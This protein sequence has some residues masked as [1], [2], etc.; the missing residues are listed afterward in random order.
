MAVAQRGLEPG[1]GLSG[2]QF[3]LLETGCANSVVRTLHE[4][5]GLDCSVRVGSY[6]IPSSHLCQGQVQLVRSGSKAHLCVSQLASQGQD[7]TQ[8]RP[9]CAVAASTSQ[10]ALLSLR[11]VPCALAG[12]LAGTWAEL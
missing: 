5:L 8:K 4:P 2:A 12:C 6:F 11:D 9:S 7:R 10:L 1:L 3:S